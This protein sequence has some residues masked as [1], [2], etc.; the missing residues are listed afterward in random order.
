MSQR[1]RYILYIILHANQKYTIIM[2]KED[3]R[4]VI[5]ETEV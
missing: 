1:S 5:P 3:K 4:P 2:N